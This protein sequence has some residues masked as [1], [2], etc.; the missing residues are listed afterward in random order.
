MSTFAEFFWKMATKLVPRAPEY[1][2][3]SSELF[4]LAVF[5]FETNHMEQEIEAVEHHFKAWSPLIENHEH[6]EVSIRPFIC[7]QH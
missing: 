5:L 2:Q 7:N 1:P 3:R 4:D 6:S